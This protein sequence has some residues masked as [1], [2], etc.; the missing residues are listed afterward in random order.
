MKSK[1]THF[2][3]PGPGVERR[4]DEILNRLSLE[5]KI[6]LLG[7]QCDPKD[8]GDTYGNARAGIPPLKMADSAL[9]VHWWT[10]RSTTYPA[11]IA[12]AA[13]WDR[14]LAYRRGAALGRD[15]R[16]RGIHILLG[17]GINLYRSPLCGRNFEYLGEDP[18][19]T[20]QSA[21]SFIRGLQDQGVSATVK[22]YALNFQ[23]YDRNHVSSDVDERT[24]REVYLP[25]FRAAVEE[26]GAGAIMTAYNLVNG[27]HCSEHAELIKVILKSEWGFQGLV[28]SDWASIY[29][30]AVEAANAG[31]DLEMPT[32]QWLNRKHLLPAVHEGRVT[33]ATIDDKVRR[34]LRLM[35]CFGW[36]DHPQQDTTIPIEDP[37]T[38]A[39]SLDVARRGC[40][41]LKNEKAMLPLSPASG[42]T[43]A[44]IGPFAERTPVNGGG[45]AYNKP[46]RT[47]SILD[48]MRKLFGPEHIRHCACLVPHSKEAAFSSSRFVTPS[49]EPGLRAEYFNNLEWSGAPVLTQV[50]PRLEQR[51][52]HGLTAEGVDAAAF[53]VRWSGSIRPMQTGIHIFYQWFAG[54]FRVR[55]DGRAI[56]ENLDGANVN[57]QRV[58]LALEAGRDYPVEVLY[59]RVGDTNGACL[60]WEFRDV[61]AE[62]E[63]ALRVARE[64]DVV[65][66]CGGHSETT[67]GEGFDRSFSLPE[68]QEY[69]LLALAEANPNIVAVITAG[70]NVDMRRWIDRVPALLYAWYPGQEG[71]TAV[72]E[73]LAGV[74]NPSG[75]LPVT[76]ERALEDRSSHGCYHDTDFDKHVALSD[77]VFVGYRHHDRTGVA[78]L[79][80]FGFGLSYTTFVYENLQLPAVMRAGKPLRVSFD[81]VNSGSRAGIEV[82]QL[83]LADVAASVP[84]PAKELKGYAAVALEAGERKTVEIVLTERDL[85][86]F[87]PR[88]RAWVAE[89]GE[90]TVHIAASAA[91]VCLTGRFN[92]AEDL[93]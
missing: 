58:M 2:T 79:F 37:S 11:T 85:Q 36:L 12:L 21:V 41:L 32:A 70:G 6:D 55:V 83:Y 18:Y 28:M 71:G 89:P 27:V 39:V 88:R 23:E 51:G 69:M 1:H 84:R 9:G 20:A 82:T 29:S 40:V 91:H 17:P 81:V 50:E 16:A 44:V 3:V 92:F 75:K 8:G 77:G 62:C 68:E 14:D 93:K 15:A 64:A 72:A 56:F 90:F 73:I 43:I 5:E 52:E 25:A 26:A 78:P 47:V 13:A 86:F 35:V 38:A 33:E 57:P 24:L 63:A 54:P 61:Q 67:E 22:H 80:P 4:V 34:L 48:G 60:G 30:G 76:F 49:G 19:L 74:V 59:R 87:C 53:S 65:I 45:S 42:K 7:G 66:F 31:L 10:D 46:W